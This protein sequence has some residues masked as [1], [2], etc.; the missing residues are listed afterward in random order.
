MAGDEPASVC[1]SLPSKPTSPRCVHMLNA[2]AMHGRG[3][4]GRG[5]CARVEDAPTIEPHSGRRQ[6][7]LVT[8][9]SAV[10]E[11][12]RDEVVV[13]EEKAEGRCTSR[14]IEVKGDGRSH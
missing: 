10:V 12:E 4:L 13:G 14:E 11:E 3:L 6:P 2:V 7:Y 5:D 1:T 8:M 9:S